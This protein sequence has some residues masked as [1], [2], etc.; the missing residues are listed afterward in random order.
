M[1]VTN[2]A[3]Y[4]CRQRSPVSAFDEDVATDRRQRIAGYRFGV[5]RSTVDRPYFEVL[6]RDLPDKAIRAEFGYHQC[7]AGVGNRTDGLSG[8]NQLASAVPRLSVPAYFDRTVILSE[9]EYQPPT[10]PCNGFC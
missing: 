2:R 10:R 3:K 5:D 1:V 8:G 9:K 6:Y 4:F 7:D